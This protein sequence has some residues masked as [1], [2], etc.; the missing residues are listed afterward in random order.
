MCCVVWGQKVKLNDKNVEYEGQIQPSKF[1]A[2]GF[3][4]LIGQLDVSLTLTVDVPDVHV[5][6]CL[7]FGKI[8][9]RIAMEVLKL[10][11]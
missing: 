8:T 2:F 4:L 10:L 3:V 1:S 9:R 7:S 5:Q 6:L 11:I